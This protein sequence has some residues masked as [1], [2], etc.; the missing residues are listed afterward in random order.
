MGSDLGRN[1]PIQAPTRM[2]ESVVPGPQAAK[3]L[4]E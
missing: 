2:G 3:I 1:P 4:K